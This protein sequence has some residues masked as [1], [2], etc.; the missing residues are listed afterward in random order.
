MLLA[1][2][3][4]ELVLG[5][6]LGKEIVH[7]RFPGD[8]LGGERVVARDHDGLDA[9]GAE[10]LEPIRQPS[11]DN[12]LEVD[13]AQRFFLRRHDQR[14]AALAGD[15]GDGIVDLG[16]ELA[17]HVGAHAVGRAL[18]VL[19]AVHVHAAH[20]RLRGEGYELGVGQLRELAPAD[21]LLLFGEHDDG[22]A[23]GG[24]VREAGELRGVGEFVGGDA[25]RGDELDGL[26]VAQR[27][28]AGLVEQEH[29]H[30]TRRLHGAAGHG[31]HVL[32][33]QPVD[34]RDADGAEQAADGRRDQ[35][36]PAAR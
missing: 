4:G 15:G 35:A 25:R 20:A 30:V 11:L 13:D 27:D 33:H 32:L 29:V 18:A 17:A 10:P 12:V 7:A 5:G 36:G 31:E 34:A 9:H 14:R 28:G 23:L 3:V 16:R 2:D 24:L 8:G 1:A 19:L 22:A 6:G 26:P 21:A